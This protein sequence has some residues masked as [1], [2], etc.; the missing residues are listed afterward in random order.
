M[1]GE[2][3]LLFTKDGL[4]KLKDLNLYD[5]VLTAFGDFEPIVEMGPWQECT[6]KVK[7]STGEEFY[8]NDDTLWGVNK[9]TSC[10]DS[11]Y[12]TDELENTYKFNKIKEFEG[13]GGSYEDEAYNYAVVIPKS[14]PNRYLLADINTRL[15][16]LAGLID[17]PMCMLGS[18]EGIYELYTRYDDLMRDIVTLLRSLAL[19]LYISKHDGVW[20]II[21]YMIKYIDIIPIQDDLKDCYDYAG[22]G[23]NLSI[24]DICELKNNN[25]VMGRKIKVNRGSFLVGY[26][27]ITVS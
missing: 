15:A 26:S 3:T 16:F 14:V 5:E 12:Y 13:F 2:D 11:F 22:V 24:N 25:K 23:L 1:L 19:P 20:R 9:N 7:I 17:S 18:N 21:I 8:C 4:K 6:K 10:C 27:L